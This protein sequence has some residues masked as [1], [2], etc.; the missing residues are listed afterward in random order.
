MRRSRHVTQHD[1]ALSAEI[2]NAFRRLYGS[3]MRFQ[4]SR[5]HH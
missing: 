3:E 2:G 5:R 1:E 4:V